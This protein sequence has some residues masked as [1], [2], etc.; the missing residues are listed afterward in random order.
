MNSAVTSAMSILK[1]TAKKIGLRLETLSINYKKEAKFH[2]SEADRCFK[3][4]FNHLSNINMLTKFKIIG[5]AVAI[6][7]LSIVS[8]TVYANVTHD[9]SKD[10][11]KYEANGTELLKQADA[12][13]LK[14]RTA[15]CKVISRLVPPCFA[16]NTVKCSQLKLE[17]E[18]YQSK[19]QVEA[20]ADCTGATQ[21]IS[22]EQVDQPIPVEVTPSSDPLFFG[23]EGQ[24]LP[25]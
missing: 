20:I 14:A 11:E 21:T 8:V 7:V 25:Q 10:V 4:S 15:Q 9:Y 13:F 6:L 5:S 12:E 22:D 17:Q 3:E 18:S 16:G 2:F 23:D 24:R 1:A 19:Y